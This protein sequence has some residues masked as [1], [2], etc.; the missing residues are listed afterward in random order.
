MSL[1][2]Q[3]G[4]RAAPATP[5]AFF[6]GLRLVSVDGSTLAVAD[7]RENRKG[8]GRPGASRGEAAFPSLR[9]SALVETGTHL[10]FAAE[11]DGVTTTEVALAER[12]LPRMDG[13]ML[14]MADRHYAGGAFLAAVADTGAR[15]LVRIR[16]DVILPVLERL[17][18]GS[19]RSQMT[20]RRSRS[21]PRRGG[22]LAVRVID[23]QV[24]PGQERF[25]LVTNLLDP[26][27]APATA[28]AALYPQRW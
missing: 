6:S 14:I 17:A 27:L 12:L 9:F 22:A 10:I 23:Y 11:M 20:D 13:S 8:L 24:A 16:Q 26:L 2:G 19:Y 7:T 4:P 5:G 1:Y 21:G 28:L 3:C 25:R 15:F 18:D